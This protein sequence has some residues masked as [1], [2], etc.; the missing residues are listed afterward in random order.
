MNPI[1]LVVTWFQALVALGCF[2]IGPL[3]LNPPAETDAD[4]EEEEKPKPKAKP[5]L[6]AKKI[7][8]E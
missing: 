5:K 8:D 1:S 7:E 3:P 6:K 4:D 2:L